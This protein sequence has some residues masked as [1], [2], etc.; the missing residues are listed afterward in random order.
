LSDVSLILFH[1]S[2]L[3]SVLCITYL[4]TLELVNGVFNFKFAKEFL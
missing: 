1:H 3:C 2:N 4:Q